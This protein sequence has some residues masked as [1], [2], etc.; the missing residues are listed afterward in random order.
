MSTKPV[1]LTI[2]LPFFNN[3]KT[4]AQAIK[5]VL[6]QTYIHFE[7]CLIDDGSTDQ[8]Y[9]IAK[10]V[11][12]EDARVTIIRDGE[13]KG[14]ISRLNQIIDFSNGLYVVR[15]DADDIMMLDKLEKQVKCF[16]EYPEID[17]VATAAY[18]IDEQNNVI[19]I[20]DIHSIQIRS[21][22]DVIK[23]SILIHPT[24]MAKKSWFVQNRYD[25]AYFRAEDYELW[26]RTFNHTAFYRITEP[27]FFYREGN[28]SL[29]NYKLSMRTLRKILKNYGKKYLGC[30]ELYIEISKTYLKNAL[31]QTFGLFKLQHI[32]SSRRN[33][34]L[35]DNQRSHARTI[36]NN[37]N[38]L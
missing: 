38:N 6:N 7:L 31:Y 2:G 12:G 29:N 5:S 35:T 36:L 8:S 21:G 19:G 20:R 34:T 30:S 17:V 3:E 15:M 24:V 9:N 33:M 11:V 1:L 28:V 13:N 4:I 23:S 22:R 16:E 25:N 26:C 37:L 10:Q 32:L 14:L 18:T 27:L